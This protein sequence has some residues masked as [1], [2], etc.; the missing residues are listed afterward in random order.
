[1]KTLPMG[2][3]LGLGVACSSDTSQNTGTPPAARTE[4]LQQITW[5]HRNARPARPLNS[6]G[7]VVWPRKMASNLLGLKSS[8]NAKE[9]AE[10]AKPERAKVG[11]KEF[12]RSATEHMAT[13]QTEVELASLLYNCPRLLRGSCP[14]PESWLSQ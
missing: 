8:Q 4:T 12:M 7:G 10:W 11:K 5:L 1:M 13:K 14:Q 3:R 2:S 9:T 6:E